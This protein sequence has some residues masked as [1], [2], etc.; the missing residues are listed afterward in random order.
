MKKETKLDAVLF[1][2]FLL[3]ILLSYIMIKGGI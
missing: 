2:I 3:M 1:I